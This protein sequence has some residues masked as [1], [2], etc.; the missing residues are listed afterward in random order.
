MGGMEAGYGEAL[1]CYNAEKRLKDHK[2]WNLDKHGYYHDAHFSKMFKHYMERCD[3]RTKKHLAT[4]LRYGDDL[5]EESVDAP[6]SRDTI[7]SDHQDDY[8]H[9]DYEDGPQGY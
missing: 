1:A 2:D 4:P 9:S 8:L 3:H 5:D 7:Y 6:P